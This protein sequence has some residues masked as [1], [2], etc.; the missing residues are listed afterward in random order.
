MFGIIIFFRALFSVTVGLI[1]DEAYHWSWSKDLMLSYYDHPGMIAWMNALSTKFFGDT[2]IGV[3][4]ASFVCYTATVFMSYKLANEI[5]DESAG[6]FVGLMLLFSPFW[7]FGGYV[8]SPEPPFMLC[9]VTAAWV[10]WQGVREDEKKWSTKKTWILL[11]IIM[12]LGLNSKFIIALLAPGFGLYLLLTKERRK[13]LLT[14]WPWVGMLIATAICLPIFLWNIEFDW[15][16]FRYQ[17]HDR[18]TGAEFSLARWLGWWAAQWMFTTPILYPLLILSFVVGF[19]RIRQTSWRFILALALPSIVMFYPQPLF[20][21]YKPH[22]SGPAYLFLMMGAGALYSKG[23]EWNYKTW[24]KPHSKR[25]RWTFILFLVPINIILYSPFVYP[26]WPK[27]YRAFNP[28]GEWNTKWD[29][30]NEFFGWDELG[31]YVNRRQREIHAETG[32]RPFIGAL[33]YETTA[34]TYWGTK[35]KTYMLSF[36]KSHYTV[37]HQHRGEWEQNYGLDALI[38]TTEKYP[39]NPIEWGKFDS[40]SP[41]ELKTYRHGEPSRTFTV[42]YCKNFQGILK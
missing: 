36:T 5:F 10:F 9:W 41:E 23:Y 18:H 12:G 8:A 13:D 25:L 26:F 35:Q 4:F 3:R 31:D 20:A 37:V 19:Q 17:F 24:I 34:Q 16:G 11:G 6:I 1:D 32:K 27:V 28:S 7:G 38:V 42:W 14:P 21:D 15:P 22:W 40:C 33:R 29:L 2:L 30:S 39:T